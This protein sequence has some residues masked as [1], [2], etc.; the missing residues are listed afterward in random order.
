MAHLSSSGRI[1][2]YGVI[3]RVSVSLIMCTGG[4]YRLV[5]HDR[6]R[7]DPSS[8]QIRRIAGPTD[9]VDA[10]ATVKTRRS[11]G[12]NWTPIDTS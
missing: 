1:H 6:Q 7:K 8:F 12:Q 5:P 3:S 10:S 2:L 11:K 9:G 4:R